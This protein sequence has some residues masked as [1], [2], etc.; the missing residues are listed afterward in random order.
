VTEFSAYRE[1]IPYARYSSRQQARG[2]S[3][4]RQVAAFEAFAAAHGVTLSTRRAIDRGLSGYK[5]ANLA[6]G[7]L[8]AL[9]EDLQCGRVETPALLLVERQDRFGRLPST[10]ALVT[11]FG[12]LLGKG[13]DIY[14]LHQSRLY[15][16][17]IIDADFGALVCLAAEVH[18]AH[19]YSATLS[20]RGRAA[21]AVA[22]DAMR[23]GRAVCP[24]WSPSWI[25]RTAT[26][27]ELNAY[28]ATILRL[29]QLVE[30]GL[31]Y[32]ATARRLNDEGHSAPRGGR[33]TPG[34]VCHALQ[35]PALAGG[36]ELL[37]GTGEI[38]WGYYPELISRPRRE[39][40]LAA[41][42]RRTAGHRQ[43][44][45]AAS[46][47]FIGQGLATC[48]ACGGAM[49]YR[50]SSYVAA[51]GQKVELN[52]VRCRGRVSGSCAVPLLPLDVTHA[53]L[54]TRLQP[55][56]LAQLMGLAAGD[57]ATAARGRVEDARR[58][59]EQARAMGNA[60]EREIAA[61]LADGEAGAVRVL[62]R[63]VAAAEQQA[64]ETEAELLQ[65]EHELVRVAAGP[66]PEL[67][68]E[69]AAAL[70]QAFA[71]GADTA[72]QRL[73][74]NRGLRQLGM[75]IVIDSQR[76]RLGLSVGGG[77]V[78]WQAIVPEQ[79]DY[80]ARGRSG[81]RSDEVGGDAVLIADGEALELQIDPYWEPA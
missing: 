5:G 4:H 48:A 43:P 60:A 36:R 73:A 61:A 3:E 28:G 59:L 77:P 78:D 57:E 49:G 53:H 14:H 27:W 24:G 52:Y 79:L 37:A 34:S 8:G 31:G 19:H 9:V 46:C 29:A 40:L 26:G 1:V 41:V 13:C 69:P 20:Q 55:Q 11:L 76:E 45:P 50:S 54:L 67:L 58:R 62:A 70:L 22:R 7:A 56:Q 15:S 2:T 6:D 75:A 18:A 39:A 35:L 64:T 63:Q 21:R 81:I 71:A 33:W 42:S 32:V 74:V 16:R 72:E 23:Q 30:Q 38:A 25:D 12:D 51:S 47:R 66:G 80:L 10:Q 44:S 65:L 68:R 17:E